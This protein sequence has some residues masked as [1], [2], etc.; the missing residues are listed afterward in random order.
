ML[1]QLFCIH[2]SMF[3]FYIFKTVGRIFFFCFNMLLKYYENS[4][5][6]SLVFPKLKL[7]LIIIPHRKTKRDEKLYKYFTSRHF[8]SFTPSL[9]TPINIRRKKNISVKILHPQQYFSYC[10]VYLRVSNVYIM[11]FMKNKRVNFFFH[12]YFLVYI[13]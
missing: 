5:W 4:A 6:K 8:Y 1:L 3:S 7:I 12:F 11:I 9:L 10:R 2:V 13:Q